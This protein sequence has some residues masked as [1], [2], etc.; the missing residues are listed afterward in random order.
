MGKGKERIP[1]GRK[2]PFGAPVSIGPL[3][4]SIVAHVIGASEPAAYSLHLDHRP[5]RPETR[6]ALIPL[7][8][9][10]Y[11]MALKQLSLF[12]LLLLCVVAW[13]LGTQHPRVFF[14]LLSFPSL[15]GVADHA[16]V[17]AD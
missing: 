16:F 9:L 2:I 12:S 13:S 14:A 11:Q 8:R 17:F 1:K 7:G 10:A 6:P 3:N 15:T 5:D 4:L